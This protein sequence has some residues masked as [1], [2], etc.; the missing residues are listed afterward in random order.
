MI[1]EGVVR[2][3]FNIMVYMLRTLEWKLSFR[4]SRI[5]LLMWYCDCFYTTTVAVVK[6]QTSHFMQFSECDPR[7]PSKI[8]LKERD[9]RN[10]LRWARPCSTATRSAFTPS[11]PNPSL[12]APLPLSIGGAF[13]L[14]HTIWI[15]I[16]SC[17]HGSWSGRVRCGLAGG[18]VVAGFGGDGRGGGG[19]H[20][21]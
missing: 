4:H 7:Y 15:G 13:A 6:D 18:K 2:L 8:R 3:D 11:L 20:G 5:C 16:Q 9:S 17:H 12:S 14:Q 1:P 10:D 21:R 19:G